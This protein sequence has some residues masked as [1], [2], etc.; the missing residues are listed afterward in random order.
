[1]RIAR[2]VNPNYYYSIGYQPLG[3]L[4]LR[5]DILERLSAKLRQKA[6][7]GTFELDPALISLVGTRKADL[8]EILDR[9]GYQQIDVSEPAQ[10]SNETNL[11]PN[12]NNSPIYKKSS[13]YGAT[14]K[15][16][17]RKKPKSGTSKVTPNPNTSP[18]AVLQ[19]LKFP[20]K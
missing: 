17:R 14:S 6:Q 8:E 19:N 12:R 18:F 11:T 20:K 10:C 9:L 2:G 16:N 1:M 7:S 15:K 5:V 3:P 4:A 13:P